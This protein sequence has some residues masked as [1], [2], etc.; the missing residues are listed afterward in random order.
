MNEHTVTWPQVMLALIM[1]IPAVLAYL[2][3]LDL[4]KRSKKNETKLEENTALTTQTHNRVEA[5]G[6]LVNG[7]M[8]QLLSAYQS[9]AQIGRTSLEEG[10]TARLAKV[11]SILTAR[12]DKAKALVH[13]AEGCGKKDGSGDGRP[14]RILIIE[15]SEIDARTVITVC[16]NLGYTFD[17]A[18]NGN[19]AIGFLSH[20]KYQAVFVDLKLPGS[21]DGF[22]LVKL[23]AATNERVPIFVV[24]GNVSER[25]RKALEMIGASAVFEK[26]VRTEDVKAAYSQLMMGANI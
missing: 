7:R 19:E 17:V 6:K 16:H 9:L 1:S 10:A 20:T 26:P 13:L 3:T 18:R 23:I 21:L 4:T 25:D 14:C 8:E 2:K 24:T 22:E 11:Q 5:V 15:D 12:E